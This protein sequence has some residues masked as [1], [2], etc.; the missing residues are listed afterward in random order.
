M[1]EAK[2]NKKRIRG[3]EKRVDNGWESRKGKEGWTTDGGDTRRLGGQRTPMWYIVYVIR[4]FTHPVCWEKS[5]VAPGCLQWL[6]ADHLHHLGDEGL[7]PTMHVRVGSPINE[8]LV[9]STF[10]LVQRTITLGRVRGERGESEGRARG[11]RGESEGRA[12]GERGEREGRE[13]GE[14]GEREGRARG[15]RGE[16]EGRER[17]ESE[18]RARGERGES[19]GRA[20]GERGEREGRERGERGESE[21]RYKG[22]RKP[23]SV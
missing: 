19:E 8:H 17:G 21:G 15:E 20:K 23:Q 11:E 10:S 22:L 4:D 13:R 14:R 3:L 1:D 16:R 18:G 6:R 2:T 7:C 9:A 5:R 12:R